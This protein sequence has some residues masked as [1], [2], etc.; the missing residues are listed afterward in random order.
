MANKF[1]SNARATALENKLITKKEFVDLIL[2]D[3]A[4]KA[5]IAIS[6]KLD[7]GYKINSVMDYEKIIENEKN[8]FFGFVKEL[9]ENEDVIDFFMTFEDYFNLE[10][11]IKSKYTSID[12]SSFLKDYGKTNLETL[13]NA[14]FNNNFEG[15]GAGLAE[16]IKKLDDKNLSLS[17]KE[18]SA[19]IK[20]CMYENLD[21]IKFKTL[22]EI[23]KTKIDL[24]N[25]ETAF[26]VDTMEEFEFFAINGG[27]LSFEELKKVFGKDETKI[28]S[29]PT[30]YKEIIQ[31]TFDE[32]KSNKPFIEIEKAIDDVG[33][34]HFEK[35]KYSLTDIEPMLR[36]CFYYLN[37]IKN[38]RIVMTGLINNLNKE[39]IIKKLRLCYER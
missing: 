34:K 27:N 29:L 8:R 17:G 16:T 25:I 30:I 15:L 6:S 10:V 32:Y 36:Y 5:L 1:Y 14:V 20:K 26:R 33:L 23:I 2:A 11:L 24:I 13:K 38:I 37:Q 39:E 31:I 7:N 22:N 35:N 18:I 3:D 4:M 9:S 19:I 12:T 28:K 21:K